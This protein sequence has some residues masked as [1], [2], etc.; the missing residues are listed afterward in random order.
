MAIEKNMFK[1]Y[2]INELNI[3]IYFGSNYFTKIQS[4]F[5]DVRFQKN[6]KIVKQFIEGNTIKFKIKT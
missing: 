6:K 5:R 2:K 3:K 4:R 1:K